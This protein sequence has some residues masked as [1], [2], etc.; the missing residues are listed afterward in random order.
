MNGQTIALKTN[1]KI[2]I[3]KDPVNYIFENNRELLTNRGLDDTR[4][5]SII[6]DDRV[7][8]VNQ[9]FIPR[10]VRNHFAKSQND[11]NPSRYSPN[12]N[13]EHD[14]KFNEDKNKN[15]DRDSHSV[16]VNTNTNLITGG[17]VNN[18]GSPHSPKFNT[19]SKDD[20]KF[21]INIIR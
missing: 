3:G 16:R 2:K 11:G 8:L 14:L 7:S 21:I 19:H 17:S 12:P 5:N 10:T 15:R 4:Q 6:K 18:D 1:D 13:N 20:S 9:E